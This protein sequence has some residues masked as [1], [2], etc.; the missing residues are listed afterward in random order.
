MP[1]R[2]EPRAGSEK[3]G[4]D[5]GRRSNHRL[6]PGTVRTQ[7]CGAWLAWFGFNYSKLHWQMEGFNARWVTIGLQFHDANCIPPGLSEGP[8]ALRG[9]GR[10]GSAQWL[11]AKSVIEGVREFASA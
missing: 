11:K 5:P 10:E 2:P 4:R 1:G 7:T 3:G 6:D 8:E 9:G